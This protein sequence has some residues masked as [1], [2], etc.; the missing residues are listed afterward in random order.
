MVFS[1]KEINL[2]YQKIFNGYEKIRLGVAVALINQ[3]NEILLEKRSDCG[4]WGVTGGKLDL[5]ETVK[6]CATREIKEECNVLVES[7]LLKLV[8]VYSDPEEGRILQ[9]PDNRVHLIDV[10]YFYKRNYFELKK[11]HESLELKFFNFNN[12]PELIVPP[13][14][15]PLND[16]SNIFT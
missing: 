6:D 5:G 14:V 7:K 10:V 4:W 1:Q 13:A 12:L 2:R 8:G 16:I 3:K 11:S 15:K 9:Y